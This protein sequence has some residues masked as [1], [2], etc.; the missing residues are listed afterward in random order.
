MVWTAGGGRR[1]G[2]LRP[3]VQAAQEPGQAFV[4][5]VSLHCQRTGLT[6]TLPDYTDKKTGELTGLRTLLASLQDRGVLM[7]D[8]WHAQ[9][10][11][12]RYSSQ[13]QRAGAAS[14][15]QPAPPGGGV[16]TQ[17]TRYYITRLRTLPV[18]ELVC[19]KL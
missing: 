18:A 16:T 19:P 3:T 5:V 6:R 1:L 2:S 10:N 15:R 4:S 7:L 13:W 8:A 12:R 17:H 11:G 14:Q 9:K